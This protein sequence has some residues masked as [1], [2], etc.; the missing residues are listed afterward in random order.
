MRPL[1][2]HPIVQIYKMRPPPI[3]RYLHTELLLYFTDLDSTDNITLDQ[4]IVSFFF[5]DRV[6]VPDDNILIDDEQCFEIGLD[7]TVKN[8]LTLVN[9][10]S[11]SFQAFVETDNKVRTI[12]QR[13]S[14]TVSLL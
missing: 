7:C 8:I 9:G 11:I 1:K 14:L 10:R 2:V 6:L 3:Q 12:T 13:I 4:T 5:G